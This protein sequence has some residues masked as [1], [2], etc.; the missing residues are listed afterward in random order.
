MGM[1]V[2]DRSVRLAVIQGQRQRLRDF[3]PDKIAERL[4]AV[5]SEVAVR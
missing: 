1:L 4:E 3:A 2:Y 5:L